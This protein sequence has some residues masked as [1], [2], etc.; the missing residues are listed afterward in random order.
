MKIEV[1]TKDKFAKNEE[2]KLI[3]KISHFYPNLKSARESKL[4]TVEGHYRREEIFQISGDVLSDFIVEEFSADSPRKLSG[5]TR[6]EMLF[7][8]GV[9][10]VLSQS[11]CQ[12]IELAGFP[13]PIS[14]KTGQAFYLAG[15]NARDACKAIKE[16]FANELIHLVKAD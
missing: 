7:K 3:K 5:Y 6:V 12:A 4:Y 10:D 1:F 8:E 9:T 11:V 16:C 15:L 13:K 2:K 14:V